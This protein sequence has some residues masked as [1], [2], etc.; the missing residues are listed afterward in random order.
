MDQDKLPLGFGFALTQ[1]P[2]SM[3]KFSELLE[4]QQAA[5]LQKARAVSSKK[6]METLVDRLSAEA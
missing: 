1:N 3:R 6:E 4:S 5:I 2:D